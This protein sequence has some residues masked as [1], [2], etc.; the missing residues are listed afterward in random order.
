MSATTPAVWVT[1]SWDDGHLLDHRVARLLAAYDLPGTFYVA[2][3]SADIAPEL[4]LG[5]RG[6]QELA[7]RFELGGHTLTHRRLPEM[8][9]DEGRAEVVAGKDT[10]E[11]LIGAEITSFAYPWG[12]HGPDDL[13]T[14]A[15]AGFTYARTVH[16]FDTTLPAH[17]LAARTTVH[18]YRHLSDLPRL[19]IRAE[20]TPR[21]RARLMAEWDALAIHLF[22]EVARTGGAYHL[23]GHSW[24]IDRFRSWKRLERVFEYISRRKDV[25]YVNNGEL[26][27]ATG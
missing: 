4:R 23:W 21:R 18:A 2:P 5:D 8:S 15:A 10:L 27:G 16:R 17:P 25:R 12:A 13:E 26:V 22:D 19:A 6:V 1:T 7:E 9:A 3:R 11:Q 14:V 24:E 20:V